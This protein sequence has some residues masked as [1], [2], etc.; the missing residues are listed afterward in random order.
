MGVAVARSLEFNTKYQKSDGI[1]N[2]GI[3]LCG[4]NVDII[5]FSSVMKDMGL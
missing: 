4:G 5:Q 2:V 3:I 1:T